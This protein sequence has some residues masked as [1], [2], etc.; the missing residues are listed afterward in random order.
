MTCLNNEIKCE[1]G[2]KFRFSIKEL[3]PEYI[4]VM[5]SDGT[6]ITISANKKTD[7]NGNSYREFNDDRLP[8]LACGGKVNSNYLKD[9]KKIFKEKFEVACKK[10][11]LD[12]CR[13]KGGHVGGVI[14]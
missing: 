1:S 4:I 7:E 14:G 5:L 11:K 13:Y 10:E 12:G 8:T 6:R 9:L 2:K 3:K